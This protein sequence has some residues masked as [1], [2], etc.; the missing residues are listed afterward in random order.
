MKSLTQLTEQCI[1]PKME[2][3]VKE[4]Y[5]LGKSEGYNQSKLNLVNIVH[6]IKTKSTEISSHVEEITRC[7]DMLDFKKNRIYNA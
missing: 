3:L 7:M 6:H 2:K 4:A 5:A 1:S